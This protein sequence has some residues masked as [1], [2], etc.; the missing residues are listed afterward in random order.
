MEEK[1]QQMQEQTEEKQPFEPS[2]K[3][4]RIF[5]WVL[6]GIVTVGIVFWLLDIADPNWTEKLLGYFGH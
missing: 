4:R 6:F 3:G 5:A 2:P 1:E